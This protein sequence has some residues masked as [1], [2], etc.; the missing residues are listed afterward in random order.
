MIIDKRMIILLVH[1]IQSRRRTIDEVPEHLRVTVQA[2][3]N[4]DQQP[5]AVV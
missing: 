2:E 3:I 1:L 4:A 5:E